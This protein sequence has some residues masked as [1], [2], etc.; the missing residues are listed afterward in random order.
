MTFTAIELQP[1]EEIIDTWPLHYSPPGGGKFEG[2]CTVTNQ[3]I[4]YATRLGQELR[5]KLAEFM[6]PSKEDREYLIIPKERIADIETEKTYLE[7]R[8]ILIL[9]NGQRHEFSYGALKI[10]RVVEAM[11]KQF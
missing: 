3:R 1:G 10:D 7:K 11:S 8:V 4:M 5:Q 2:R 9:D 6:D